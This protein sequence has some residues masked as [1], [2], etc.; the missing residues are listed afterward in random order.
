MTILVYPGRHARHLIGMHT[1][2]EDRDQARW[3][4]RFHPAPAAPVR[5]VCF[6]HA[7][8]S[9]TYFR[10]LSAALSPAVDVQAVQ[11]P[12]RQE[13]HMEPLIP[14]LA[15]LADLTAQVVVPDGRATAF[16]GH[17][18]GATV[19]FEVARRWEEQNRILLSL[20]TSGR[21]APS[22]PPKERVALDT[23]DDVLLELAKLD[24]TD[25]RLLVDEDVRQ[26]ILPVIGNDYRAAET[27]R[28]SDGATVR[29]PIV[30]LRGA[31]DPRVSEPEAQRWRVHTAGR[32][33]AHTFTGGHFYIDSNIGA[34]ASLIAAELGAATPAR[35]ARP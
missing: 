27:Y 11:Y 25:P 24:G 26:M 19:A 2:V 21:R 28:C 15:T 13:R 17:S 9:A 1:S 3:L 4:R 14:D 20:F 31:S 23:D 32:F 16:F 30:M 10:Q 8:G 33:T 6:P 29:C 12:G 18:M 35:A 22:I 7:G 5:L 34:V